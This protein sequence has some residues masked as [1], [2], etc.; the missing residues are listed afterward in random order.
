MKTSIHRRS[1]FSLIE[2]ALALGIASFALLTLFGLLP[3]GINNNQ[4][5]IEQ[6]M[7]TN[8]TTAII[9]DL[10]EA[11][12][13]SMIAA[14]AGLH[15]VSPQYNIDVTKTS[16]QIIY[17][18]NSGSLQPSSGGSARYKATIVLAQ[19]SSAG[20]SPLR[21][22]TLGNITVSWPA[23]APSPLGAISTYVGLDRN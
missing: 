9:S 3:L 17:L 19:S 16:P 5:S 21:T 13:T 1:A 12:N 6:T 20:A 18:D 22:A 10:R 2:V 4:A 11:P 15:P 8:I 14:R 7:A 23:P